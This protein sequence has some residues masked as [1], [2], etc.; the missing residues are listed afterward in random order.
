MTFNIGDFVRGSDQHINP[1]RMF[2]YGVVVDQWGSG[3]L[4]AWF[5]DLTHQYAPDYELTFFKENRYAA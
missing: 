5:D 2:D 1:K 3:Y 4:V